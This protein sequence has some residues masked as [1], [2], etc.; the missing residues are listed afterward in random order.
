MTT[1]DLIGAGFGPAAI[2]LATAI[3]D[4][5]EF[6]AE[7]ARPVRAL[8]LERAPSVVWQPNMLLPGTDIQHHFL[9]DF[10][11]PRNPRSRFTFPNYLKETG[12]LYPFGLLGNYV[13]RLEWSRYVEW[14]A[15]QLDQ[16]VL[17]DH[18]VVEVSP[19]LDGSR[20]VEARVTSRDTA[21]G[22]TRQDTARNVMVATGHQPW[23]PE[24]F[25][26]HLG[27]RVF[28]ASD[29]LPR[30]EP[31]EVHQ[32]LR[33]ALVGAGQNAGEIFMHLTQTFPNAQ[34]HSVARNSGFRM[35]NLG[36][37]SN[38]AYFPEETD[39]FYSLDADHRASVY[40]EVHS[41]NYACI[42]PD[43]STAMYRT[44]YEDRYFGRRRLH[45]R[46]RTAVERCAPLPDGGYRLD[47]ADVHTGTQGQLDADIVILCTGFRE[48]RLPAMLEPFLPYLTSD[49]AGDPVL[50]RAYRLGT[51]PGCEVGIYLNGISEWRHGINTAASFS[52]LALK[53]GEIL[54]DLQAHLRASAARPDHADA[55][56]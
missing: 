7:P 31:L 25:V 28:H 10:A 18:E 24:G 50:S 41:T 21:T 39:Y 30:I 14:T 47:L 20:V 6:L 17:F 9:R 16:Q 37:F 19:V 33:F 49:E 3:E 48:P 56:H 38:E 8:F 53:G 55:V 35:Y 42:D 27:E 51:V 13:S 29:F 32:P 5:A 22:A 43:L 26:E 45:L 12:R 15:E 1:L 11:S 34:I 4:E 44:V 54:E 52:V 23:V 46:K 36:H 2:A 40:D